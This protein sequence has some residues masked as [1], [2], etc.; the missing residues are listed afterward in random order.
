M[1]AQKNHVRRVQTERFVIHSFAHSE[2]VG[3]IVGCRFVKG[4]EF[5]VVANAW[6]HITS[7]F[8]SLPLSVGCPWSSETL[9]DVVLMWTPHT[10]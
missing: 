5:V 10:C 1:L 3:V 6:P 9:F 2:R 4:G 8:L 7:V